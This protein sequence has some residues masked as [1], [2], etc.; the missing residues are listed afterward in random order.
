MRN[1]IKVLNNNKTKV[2]LDQSIFSAFGFA[3]NLL[4][5]RSMSL[6]EFG[7]YSSF[8]LILQLVISISN[9]IIIQ[10]F[11][12]ASKSLTS[13]QD[14]HSFLV[15]LQ[16]MFI[17]L[18][19]CNTFVILNFVTQ[20]NIS[21]FKLSLFITSYLFH[22]FFRKYYLGKHEILLVL[23]M[24]SFVSITQLF[25]ILLL[26]YLKV[27]NI[28]NIFFVLGLSYSVSTLYLCFDLQ[29][30][31]LETRNFKEFISYHK[32]EGAWLSL[33]SLVQWSSSNIFILPLAV[34]VNVEALGAFRLVQSLFGILNIVFQT[35]E[36]YVLPQA[37][38]IY[39]ESVHLSKKY[40][41]S[42]SKQSMFAVGIALG[43][44]FLFSEQIMLLVGGERYLQYHFVIRGMSCLYFILF[45]GYPIRLSIRMLLLTRTFFVGYLISFVISLLFFKSLVNHYQINGVMIGLIMNQMIVLL[46]WNFNLMKQKFYLWK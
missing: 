37:C 36:N 32:K 10:P 27:L 46:F 3:V 26:I 28:N 33:V 35:Y 24:D 5:A 14:Y 21:Y 6:Y 41:L 11:Q 7:I 31:Q 8:I 18:C 34:I 22:D 17:V 4:L 23:L 2:L 20:L 12:S 40:L 42:I 45:M 29:Q 43:L 19:L 39:E 38:K 1:I 30:L 16:A 15:M 44:L 25:G 9:A 13:N